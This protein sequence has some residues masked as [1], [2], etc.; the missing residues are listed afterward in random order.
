MTQ[1]QGL[2]DNF[3]TTINDVLKQQIITLP[4]LLKLS[5]SERDALLA[6]QVA[7]ITEYF[8]PGSSQMEW[9]EEYVENDNWDGD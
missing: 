7:T 1:K 9:V 8:T 3:D 6:Q 5:P 2:I 4:A